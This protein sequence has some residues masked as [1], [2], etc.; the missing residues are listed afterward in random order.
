MKNGIR[1][2]GSEVRAGLKKRVARGKFQIA[3]EKNLKPCAFLLPIAPRKIFMPCGAPWG[4][5][6]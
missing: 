2:R 6:A 1:G 3:S 5:R 4:I